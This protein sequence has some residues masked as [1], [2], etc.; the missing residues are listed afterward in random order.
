M[1][2][3]VRAIEIFETVWRL[4]RVVE[5][6]VTNYDLLRRAQDGRELTR[7]ELAVLIATAKLALQDAIERGDLARSDEM[8]GDLH[9]AFP[10]A[11][12][13][14]FA[15]A[16]DDHRLRAEIVATKLANRIVNRPGVLHPPDIADE[17]GASTLDNAALLV[18]A[19]AEERP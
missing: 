7:P 10:S 15:G 3:D 2:G 1:P 16:I 18:E 6:L 8:K 14:K 17:D 5:G 19:R 9:A 4:E 12:R 11:M 13:K